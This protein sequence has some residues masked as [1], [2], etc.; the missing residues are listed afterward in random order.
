MGKKKDRKATIFRL[1]TKVASELTRIAEETGVSVNQLVNGI[2]K[3]AVQNAH[4]GEAEYQ[5][6]YDIGTNEVAG[7]V[8]F[9]DY[10]EEFEYEDPDTREMR[11]SH[12]EVNFCFQLDFTKT[13]ITR[14]IIRED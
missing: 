2:L 1:E 5:G 10:G 14:R 7:C 12:T 4:V 6:S 8:W 9:G 3:W 13:R 11:P